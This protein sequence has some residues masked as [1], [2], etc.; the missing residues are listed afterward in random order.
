MVILLYIQVR[1]FLQLPM[2]GVVLQSY[3]AGNAPDNRPDLLEVIE[4]ASNREVIIL[5]IT[6]CT[7]GCVDATYATGKVLA[8]FRSISV[9]LHGP[10]T[11]VVIWD[12][13][14]SR[15]LGCSLYVCVYWRLLCWVFC[16]L[17][18]HTFIG[19]F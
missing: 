8:I 17:L 3:G 4:D 9:T 18:Y 10:L 2:Q 14:Y 12:Q 16:L 13:A 7:R 19:I 1:S 5:N 15:W 11:A 6:Q